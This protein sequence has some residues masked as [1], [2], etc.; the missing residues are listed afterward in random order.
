MHDLNLVIQKHECLLYF[1]CDEICSLPYKL[2]HNPSWNAI[3][4]ILE[5]FVLHNIIDLNNTIIILCDPHTI[6]FSARPSLASSFGMAHSNSFFPISKKSSFTRFSN[7]YSIIKTRE[8]VRGE[9][10]PLTFSSQESGRV[11]NAHNP[12][13]GE[14]LA[15][16]N[17][18]LRKGILDAATFYM[19]LATHFIP[20]IP[21]ARPVVLLVDSAD[22]HIDL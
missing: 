5:E 9:S 22:A 4:S 19:W 8:G 15:V 11:P 21:S 12:L 6:H 3:L 2:V 14:Y 1:S 13:D 20:N 16:H 18:L 10:C 7:F 17:P